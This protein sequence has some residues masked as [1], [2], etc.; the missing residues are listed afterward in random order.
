MMTNTLT[1]AVLGGGHG[2]FCMA[3]EL[4]LRNFRVHL[5]ELP[6][7]A[8]TV[9]PVIQAGGIALRG[10]AGEGFARP[11]V[12]TTD[13]ERA[14]AG[15]DAAMVVVPAYG[16]RPMAQACAPYLKDGQIVVLAPGCCGGALEFRQTLR[17]FGSRAE[18]ILAEVTSLPY[19][20]KKETPTSVWA[21]GKKKYLPLAALPATRTKWVLE[22]LRPAF[23]QFTPAANVLDTSF[24]NVN[25][26]IHPPPALLNLGLVESQRIGE[27]SFY[28]DGYSPAVAQVGEALDVERMGI[29]RAFGLPEVSLLEWGPIYYGHQGIGGKSLYQMVQT[30]SVHGPAP[31]PKMTNERQISEDVPYGLVPLASFGRLAGAPA[32]TMEALIT[33]SGVVN[34]TDYWRT[35]RTVESLGLAGMSVD[36]IVRFV[37]AAP[38]A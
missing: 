24:N 29:I 34:G 17:E 32:P 28:L 20:V 27:W 36:E 9:E 16:H 5:F 14:L 38:T 33:L 23:P 13:I 19:A 2:G 6:S 26:I 15:V 10:V 11:A 21:R 1:F 31:G 18:I 4:T 3:A 25:N 35:G 30:P 12:V 7:F 37:T 22:R 8:W